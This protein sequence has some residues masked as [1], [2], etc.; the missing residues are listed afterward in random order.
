MVFA[1]QPSLPKWNA[2]EGYTEILN[3]RLVER[4]KNT[5]IGREID[6]YIDR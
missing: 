5:C 1:C 3:E 4:N 2:G 6:K